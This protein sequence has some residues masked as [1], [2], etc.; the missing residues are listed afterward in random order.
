MR[1][2]TRWDYFPTQVP[3]LGRGSGYE[4]YTYIEAL[5]SG[6]WDLGFRGDTY[7]GAAR[8]AAGRFPTAPPARNLDGRPGWPRRAVPARRPHSQ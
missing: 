3:D 6:I 2:E 1:W 8:V 4:G 7:Q 5:A